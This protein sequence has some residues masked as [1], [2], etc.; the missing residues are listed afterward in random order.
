[1]SDPNNPYKPYTHQAA[2][3]DQKFDDNRRRQ[4]EEAD[5]AAQSLIDSNRRLVDSLSR[6]VSPPPPRPPAAQP[7][8]GQ[9]DYPL[10]PDGV[11]VPPPPPPEPGAFERAVVWFLGH[12]PLAPLVASASSLRAAS[13][14]ARCVSAL[15][16]VVFGLLVLAIFQADLGD[17][18][19]LF[20]A[21]L[22]LVPL[23]F[24]L[25]TMLAAALEAVATVVAAIL[26]LVAL[27]TLIVCCY[28][29]G[30]LILR[31][32]GLIQ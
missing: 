13:T 8:V 18:R 26:V 31:L 3:H 28:A 20:F 21:L 10:R 19:V 14:T 30:R 7:W 32:A 2:D 23:G 25:P 27:G 6:P 29:I 12:W 5:A 9:P 1:M 4:K 22:V 16:V 15:A 17:V 24:F 11:K